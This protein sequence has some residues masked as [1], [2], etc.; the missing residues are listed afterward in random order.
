MAYLLSYFFLKKERNG[1]VTKLKL[2]TINKYINKIS[3]KILN[4]P[5]KLK[6]IKLTKKINMYI[7]VG[8]CDVLI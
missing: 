4:N 7:V 3:S 8:P 6:S 1:K 5:A 2:T